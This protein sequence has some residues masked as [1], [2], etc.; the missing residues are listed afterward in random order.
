MNRCQ[1]YCQKHPLTGVFLIQLLTCFFLLNCSPVAAQVAIAFSKP[2]GFYPEIFTLSIETENGGNAPLQIRYTLNG[3]VPTANSLLYKRPLA[4]DR[5]LYSPSNIYKIPNTIPQYQS[6]VPDGVEHIVVVRAAAFNAEG[7]RCSDVITASYLIAPLLGRKIEL[8]VLSLCVDS[9]DLFDPDK[10]IFVPGNSFDPARP[11]ATGNYYLRGRDNEKEGYLEFI[12]GTISFAQSCGVRTHGNRG[13]R[14][15]QKGLSLYARKEYGN[16]RFGPV[17]GDDDF[18]TK[19]LVLKPFACAWTPMG[20]QDLYCQQ[21]AKYYS[22]FA[23]LQARP[24]VL[25]LNGE[26]W[27][28]YFLEEK[29]DE[30]YLEDHFGVDRNSVSLVE[31]WAGHNGDGDIDSAFAAMMDWMRTA[32]LSDDRQYEQLSK[33][34]DIASFTD[35]VLFETF[36]GN[37]DWP[38][39][40]M[41]CWSDDGSPWQFIFFDGDAIR[42]RYFDCV[43]NALYEGTDKSWPT[44]AKATLLLRRLLQNLGYRAFFVERLDEVQRLFSS[45]SRVDREI[46]EQTAASLKSEIPYQSKR[47]GFPK[48]SRSWRQ[49]VRQQRHYWR[50]RGDEVR[51]AWLQTVGEYNGESCPTGWPVGRWVAL[52]VA[53]VAALVALVLFI[54]RRR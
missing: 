41:R 49:A 25:F 36:I 29:P 26:Y 38:A 27:G 50:H 14:Y 8:P 30:R 48:S 10:G 28:I 47:F 42:T 35:Y 31:D 3:A 11:D 51:R 5:T 19:R 13:R 34:V 37:R 6:P 43:G 32:N 2:G 9:F 22:S 16:K 52:I 54:R 7:E 17:F 33:R 12:D 46:F 39:N 53:G 24:V 1:P 40:N 45:A 23:S 21:L 18:E 4:M 20:F 44:S 15:A